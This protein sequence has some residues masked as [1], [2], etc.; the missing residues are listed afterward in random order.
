MDLLDVHFL[1]LI[2]ENNSL[3]IAQAFMQASTIWKN[4][5]ITQVV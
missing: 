3:K 5:Q 4:F 1:W 2:F